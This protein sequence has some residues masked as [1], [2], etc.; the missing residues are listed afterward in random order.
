MSTFL[1]QSHPHSAGIL[2]NLA[3]K[4]GNVEVEIRRIGEII[5]GEPREY[6]VDRNEEVAI[7]LSMIDGF[8]QPPWL[9]FH[10]DFS[11]KESL[12]ALAPT[13]EHF[14]RHAPRRIV[15][16]PSQATTRNRTQ[17]KISSIEG[18]SRIVE[19]ITLDHIHL[20]AC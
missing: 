6:E 8:S 20:L 17:P 14:R 10:F 9:V 7:E 19:T 5:K 12:A 4:L 1:F 13:A 18:E 11:V 15:K 3:G 16:N 2:S